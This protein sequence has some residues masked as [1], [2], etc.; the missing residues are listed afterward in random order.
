MDKHWQP[1]FGKYRSVSSVERDVGAWRTG[2]AQ[3]SDLVCC[4]S[5][6]LIQQLNPP[7]SSENL[8]DAVVAQQWRTVF[9]CYQQQSRI[10]GV[11]CILASCSGA[12]SELVERFLRHSDMRVDC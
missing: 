3:P 11:L 8:I 4:Q 2:C 6:D 12:T 10:V 9:S 5:K 7:R 1:D